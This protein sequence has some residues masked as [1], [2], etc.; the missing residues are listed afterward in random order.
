MEVNK[1]TSRQCCGWFSKEP[2]TLG[3]V[4]ICT[5]FSIDFWKIFF[6]S[7]CN[8]YFLLNGFIIL[9]HVLFSSSEKRQQ[10]KEAKAA[11][12]AARLVNSKPKASNDASLPE[13]VVCAFETGLLLSSGAEFGADKLGS[14]ASASA[15]NHRQAQQSINL[16][17][18][19]DGMKRP[20]L[21]GFDHSG[22]EESM[23]VTTGA[24]SSD[25]LASTVAE[26][27]CDGLE[28]GDCHPLVQEDV[29]F[30]ETQRPREENTTSVSC[31]GFEHS[32]V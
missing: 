6:R 2:I 23:L 22:T 3:S 21:K 17:E 27:G 30:D 15:M 28:S 26:G 31:S 14:I 24:L 8:W 7:C 20:F 25:Y 19:Q 18:F 16:Q 29:P 12:K 10:K 4:A 11:R 1:I 32:I 5:L 9:T 13:D